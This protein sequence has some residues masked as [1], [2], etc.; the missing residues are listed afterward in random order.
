MAIV[1]NYWA[2]FHSCK[3][4]DIEQMGNLFTLI[5]TIKKPKMS[6]LFLL[7]LRQFEA[8]ETVD[9]RF[10]QHHRNKTFCIQG[11]ENSTDNYLL[12]YYYLIVPTQSREMAYIEQASSN[13][14]YPKY[15]EHKVERVGMC[16]SCLHAV[17]RFH[18]FHPSTSYQG[19]LLSSG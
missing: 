4:P 2:N 8:S 11:Q 6:F 12:Y 5:K 16:Y 7:S 14:F 19:I 10:K 13:T 9:S 15:L 3:W 18:H 17:A 1:L